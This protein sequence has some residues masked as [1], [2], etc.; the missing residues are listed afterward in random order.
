MRLEKLPN[1]CSY[2]SAFRQSQEREVSFFFSPYFLMNTAIAI[3]MQKWMWIKY[4]PAGEIACFFSDQCNQSPNLNE[5][6]D[7]HIH[8][9]KATHSDFSF[10]T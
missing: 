3:S 2:S 7:S 10:A 9:K 5:S 1:S 4:C 6:L 8:A